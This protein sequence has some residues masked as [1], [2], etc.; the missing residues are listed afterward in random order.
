MDPLEQ[1]AASK[2]IALP[3]ADPLAAYA[4]A[5]GI[6]VE[7]TPAPAPPELGVGERIGQG[8]AAVNS[9]VDRATLGIPTMLLRGLGKLGVTPAGNMAAGI[10]RYRNDNPRL[11]AA[12]D[13]PA[14]LE[15]G[16][17]G[18]IAK[19]VDRLIPQGESALARAGSTALSGAAT[20]AALTEAEDATKG[21]KSLKEAGKDIGLSSLWGGVFGAGL[22]GLGALS[23]KVLD[24]KGGEARR[25]IEDRG[26]EVG[27]TSPG[28][29]PIF[30]SMDVKGNTAAD[31]GDQARKSGENVE[32]G[33]NEY[34]FAKATQ[35]YMS[36]KS[37]IPQDVLETP[38]VPID[39]T[40]SE[41]QS[42]IQKQQDPVARNAMREQYAT[43]D[44]S[45]TPRSEPAP[46]TTPKIEALRALID[47]AKEPTSKA[48]LQ[49]LLDKETAA[50]GPPQGP[51]RPRMYTHEAANDLRK[52]LGRNAGI[53]E[54]NAASKQPQREQFADLKEKVDQGPLAPANK[55]FHEGMND[56][57]ESMNMLD[58]KKN[59]KPGA[60][61]ANIRKATI[62]G[63]RRG[64]NTVTAGAERSRLDDF[65]AKHPDLGL[66]LERPEILRK[67]ADL[68]FNL[69][70]AGLHAPLTD[71]ARHNILPALAATLLHQA[72]MGKAAWAT[73]LAN[74]AAHNAKP[75]TGRV[76]YNPAKAGAA[77]ADEIPMSLLYKAARGN[78]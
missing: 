28:K 46:G 26:G 4:S 62:K 50:M 36:L 68:Q 44:Q 61:E 22:G 25:Y 74:L 63:Q 55:A 17:P 20:N 31:I 70:G 15:G 37:K 16:G 45:A 39:D 77:V 54:S 59:K 48:H 2:G 5:K 56:Y 47:D 40:M 7:Q 42:Q 24:S 67:Q 72:G 3:Q 75:L 11:S 6:A 32:A 49:G 19:G 60:N 33:L 27:V 65:T 1:Y 66:E 73:I 35:P 51:I 30:D 9:T 76:L 29:G 12:T 8:M 14:Y 52:V 23:S 13:M 58:L 53:G 38:A 78:E 57:E 71:I 10:D 64:Q 21:G 41:L 69:G 18:A 43:M 34:K